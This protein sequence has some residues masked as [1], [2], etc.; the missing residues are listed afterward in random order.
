MVFRF[1]MPEEWKGPTQK[2]DDFAYL[3]PK[4]YKPA[5]RTDGLIFADAKM[6]DQVKKDFAPEQV[7]NVATMPGIVGRSMAMP[8]IQWG[9]GFPI[10]GVAAFDYDEGVFSPGGNGFDI[11]CGVRLVRT[12]L[13]E[14]DVRPKLKELVDACFHNVPSGVG[15][16]GIV[17]V[18][19][20]D[21]KELTE[22]GV[23][24]AVEKGY[25]W[26][27]D[28]EYIETNGRLP[29][30]DFSKISERAIARG[31]DQVGSLG[32]GNHFVEIQ[33]VDKVYD[34]VAAKAL[35]ID[36]PGRVC[37]MIH[38][39]SRGFGHQVAT[40]YI[41][42]AER[43]MKTY[44]IERPDRQLACARTHARAGGECWKTLS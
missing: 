22:N 42:I 32:A 7:A 33:K 28:P 10:G 3:I 41:A 12:D 6:M 44:G 25:A 26:P 34:E 39:G 20:S 29:D 23:Q 27:E 15:E 11:L 21:L 24:W 40:D 13:R 4:S 9:Y 14:T 31:K 5:M 18:G 35:G 38:T 43:A 19:R 8:D 1:S 30:A 36:E 16:G 2:L 17:K 37:V